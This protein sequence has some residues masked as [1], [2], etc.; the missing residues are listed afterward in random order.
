MKLQD[1]EIRELAASDYHKWVD[2]YNVY[3][4]HYDIE[5]RSKGLSVTWG[6][7]MDQSHP[8]KGLCCI[9]N[10]ELLG[11]A[12]YREA[13]SPLEGENMGFLDDL[14]VHHKFRRNGIAQLLLKTLTERS[15]E[16]GW[17]TVWWVTKENNYEARKVYDKVARKTDWALYEM[18][19]T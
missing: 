15:K 10:G 4:K 11:L 9:S 2:I 7:L 16:L 6:W 1:L 18:D 12:H 3:A 17:R 14:V 13:P 8:L 5:L 19:I